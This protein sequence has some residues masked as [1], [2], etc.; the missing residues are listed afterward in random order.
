MT[1]PA[2]LFPRQPVPALELPT[3]GGDTWRL[4]DQSPGNF[5]MVNFYRGLHCP[6]CS[7]YLGDLNAKAGEFASR[8]VSI[9]VASSDDADRAAKAKADWKLDA[10]TVGY[11]L[12]VETA[13]QWG[14]F[15]SSG[16]G[17]TSIG[18]EE[19]ALF[20]EPGLFLIRADGTLYFSTIQ[21]MPF[22]R[23]AFAD[24]LTAL[25]FVLKNDYPGRGEVVG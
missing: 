15:I 20:A 22:A 25:D 9:L 8:G 3:V 7:R 5:T 12:S 17:K 21:T 6:I 13:R 11:G 10:L 14:L 24:I 1:N 4:A 16:R 23:P 19:P 2:T 18:V